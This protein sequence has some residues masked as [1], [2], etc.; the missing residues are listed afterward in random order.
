[1]LSADFREPVFVRVADDLGNAGQSGDFFGSTLSIAAGDDNL[2]IGI[3]AMYP[4]DGGAGVM[5]GGR[6]DGAGIKDDNSGGDWIGRALKA[7]LLELALD[8]SA[9]GLGG[10]AS[11]ILHVESCHESSV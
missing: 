7:A 8:G 11:E 9:V 10:A 5:I 1:M 4:A 3:L 6:G 2:T